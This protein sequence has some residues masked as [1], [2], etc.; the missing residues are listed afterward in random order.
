MKIRAALLSLLLIGPVLAGCKPPPPSDPVAEVRQIMAPTGSL[1]VALY[2]GTPT[3]VLSE[4]DRRGVGYDIGQEMARRLNV[5]FVPIIHENN[6][7]VQATMKAK[8]ADLAFANPNADRM[9]DMDFTQSHLQIEL[10]YLAAPKT[11]TV[12]I[13]EVDRPGVRVG[14]TAGS[15]SLVALTRDFKNAKVVT[16]P[17]FDAGLEM[18]AKGDLDFYATNKA[19]LGA[20]ADRLPGSRILDGSWGVER[21]AMALPKG[22]EAALP[23]AKAFVTDVVGKGLVKAA[24]A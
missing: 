5:P 4:A 15:S 9:K 12:L 14:V 22:R 10:G 7:A 13:E 11:K 1:R 8:N 23:F 19:N 21:H 3:S 2:R 16:A 24:V 6:A 17:T 18:L 20:M